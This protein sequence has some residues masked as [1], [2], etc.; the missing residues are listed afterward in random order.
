MLGRSM[1]GED[2]SSNISKRDKG[3]SEIGEDNW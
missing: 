1:G 2:V 3:V